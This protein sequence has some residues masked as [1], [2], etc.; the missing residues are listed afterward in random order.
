MNSSSSA[1]T[2]D[3]ETSGDEPVRRLPMVVTSL[4]GVRYIGYHARHVMPQTNGERRVMPRIGTAIGQGETCA[5]CLRT[6]EE[7]FTH[8]VQPCRHLMHSICFLR[9]FIENGISVDNGSVFCPACHHR[10]L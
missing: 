4:Q 6:I 3:S 10:D 1:Y 9:N 8:N 2:Q 5:F 7:K